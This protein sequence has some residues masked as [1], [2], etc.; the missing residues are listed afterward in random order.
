[1]NVSLERARFNV[2]RPRPPLQVSCA[3]GPLA[4]GMHTTINVTFTGQALGHYTGSVHLTSELNTF[5][6]SVSAKVEPAM[7]SLESLD[8]MFPSMSLGGV[9]RGSIAG[10]NRGSIAGTPDLESR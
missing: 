1:M 9:S 4:A 3:T 6:V 2:H 10:I 8:S 7:S 5:S